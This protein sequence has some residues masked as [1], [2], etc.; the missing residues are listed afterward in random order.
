MQARPDYNQR[1]YTKN[2]HSGFLHTNYDHFLLCKLCAGR[3]KFHLTIIL[4]LSLILQETYFQE[5]CNYTSNQYSAR[6][7]STKRF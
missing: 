1:T 7:A 3:I 6:V 4:D 2:C 5:L